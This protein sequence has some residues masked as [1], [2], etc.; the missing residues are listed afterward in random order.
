MR[1]GHSFL[2]LILLL[3]P[4]LQQLC[5]VVPTRP[6]YG[7]EQNV[8]SPDLT[9]SDWWT[10]DFQSGY[11][12]WHRENVGF[13]SELVRIRNQKDYELYGKVHAFEVVVGKNGY[14]FAEPYLNSWTGMDGLGE[15]RIREL[16]GLLL[17]IQDALKK[18]GKT[19]I[20]ALAAGKASFF[21]EFVPPRFAAL[22]QH[23]NDGELMGAI[24]QDVG[25]NLLD[26]NSEF[27]ARKNAAPYPL[28]GQT[29]IHW[30]NYG[31]A[32]SMQEFIKRVELERGT[33]LADFHIRKA[34]LSHELR[35]P[36]DDLGNL[37]NLLIPIRHYP[38]AIVDGK[39]ESSEGH[40]T[41]R[42]TAFA[43]SFFWQFV[44]FGLVPGCF[45]EGD[46]FFY[47]QAV[48]HS[49]TSPDIGTKWD[50]ETATI[51][52][53]LKSVDDSDVILIL[54]TEANYNGIGFGYLDALHAHLQDERNG[55]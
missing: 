35:D 20:V 46:C 36:D 51:E 29:G 41:P 53:A 26:Y 21:P 23:Q 2:L 18:R 1:G 19:F 33:D 4:L 37:I 31:A 32:L 30:S 39:W 22:R 16:A 43:D 3:A 17:D 54:V 15:D 11:D 24:F 9:V 42:L 44:D 27:K 14:L 50:Q 13:R 7:V 38:M 48:Y 40:E 34:S 25:I 47:D 6:L 55:P 10:G 5:P 52:A 49:P 8:P 28:F 12:R 45:R